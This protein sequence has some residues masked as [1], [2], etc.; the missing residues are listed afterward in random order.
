M[1]KLLYFVAVAVV[2]ML[3]FVPSAFAAQGTTGFVKVEEEREVTVLQPTGGGSFGGAAVILPAAAALLAG[4]GI[5]AYAA[6]SR[7]RHS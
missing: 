7:R 4:S 1:K 5:L 2:A 3:I 6:L